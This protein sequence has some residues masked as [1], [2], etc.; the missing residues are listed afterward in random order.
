[1]SDLFYAENLS[2]QQIVEDSPIASEKDNPSDETIRVEKF[3]QF[4]LKE[5]SAIDLQLIERL[6]SQRNAPMLNEGWAKTI[7]LSAKILKITN[8]FVVSE[9]II[10]KENNYT[11]I[12]EFPKLLFNHIEPISVG[13]FVKIKISQKPG[14]TRTD[15][16]DGKGLGIDKDFEMLDAWKDLENFEMDKPF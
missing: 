11:Q 1:M 9:C 3:M 6:I 2:N 15:I 7:F 14:S 12:R 16:I 4:E 8:S 10:S 13:Q 5:E